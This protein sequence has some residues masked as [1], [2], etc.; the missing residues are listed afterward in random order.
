VRIAS[1]GTVPVVHAELAVLPGV[2]VML[3]EFAG[4]NVPLHVDAVMAV[5]AG[6]PKDVTDTFVAEINPLLVTVSVLD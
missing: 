1:T 5:P 6:S 4:P 3:H 2:I